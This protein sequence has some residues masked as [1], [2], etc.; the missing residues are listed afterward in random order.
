MRYIQV[1]RGLNYRPTVG[2]IKRTVVTYSPSYE[3]SGSKNNNHQVREFIST[4]LICSIAFIAVMTVVM[5]KL[6]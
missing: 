5:E 4:F 2:Y 1:I 6:Q 3:L